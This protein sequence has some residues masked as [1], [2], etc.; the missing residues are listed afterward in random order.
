MNAQ[1]FDADILVVGLGP[2]GAALSAL[3]ISKG[4]SVVAIDKDTSV[5]PLPR[6]VHFDA[7]IMRLFQQLG[8]AEQVGRNADA[9]PDYEFRT[10]A[11]E[12]LFCATPTAIAPSGWASGYMFHQ[13]SLE[14]ALRDILNVSPL[15]DIRLGCSFDD[16]SQDAAGV[17]ATLSGPNGLQQVHTRY[18]IGC[19]GGASRVRKA[20]GTTLF[21][22]GFDEPWLV[23]DVN[24]KAASNVPKVN[25]QI[26][27][28]ARPTTCVLSGPGRHRWEF[29]L[30]PGETSEHALQ[31]SFVAELLEPWSCGDV[32]IERRA[33]Y[34][35]HGLVAKDWRKDRVILAGDSA[36]QTPP[37][38]GQG[39]CSGLRDAANLAWKL[40][41]ILNGTAS[42]DLLDTYQAER[43]PH[44][45]SLIELAIGMG[46]VVC[47]LDHEIAAK[48]DSELLAKQASGDTSLPPLGAPP[49]QA[50][51]LMVETSGAGEVFPQPTAGR[52]TR[53]LRM[54]DALPDTAWLISKAPTPASHPDIE[55]IDLSDASLAPFTDSLLAWFDQHNAEAVLVRPDRYVFGTG[56]PEDLIRNWDERVSKQ[57]VAQA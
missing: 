55:S 44:T 8:I 7:E 25:L 29:M 26:C 6:A 57:L 17:T 33:V 10:A 13:P 21:D 48:R 53:K 32:E 4:I 16:L 11:R 40:D 38:A 52:G 1:K 49:L 42:D 28:P 46:K 37:F 23:V 15:A 12:L 45:R 47:T 22:Y 20:I 41:A 30:L 36:H 51:C 50:G 31:D 18:L 43:E 54:D 27:D 19:D 24:V 9:L 14:Y 3:L 35:F 2:V 56:S 39:M 34:N 5:Y